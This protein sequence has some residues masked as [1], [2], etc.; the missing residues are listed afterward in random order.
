MRRTSSITDEDLILLQQQ[1]GTRISY[2]VNRPP[3]EIAVRESK[4]PLGSGLS[5]QINEKHLT[6]LRL[7]LEQNSSFK[8]TSN[9]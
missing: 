2:L 7:I 1:T 6:E 9:L 8:S 4:Y 5:H 3:I